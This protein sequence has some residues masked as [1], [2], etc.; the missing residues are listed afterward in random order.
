MPSVVPVPVPMAEQGDGS[1]AG[2]VQSGS[3]EGRRLG[4]KDFGGNWAAAATCGRAH[5]PINQRIWKGSGPPEH[6]GSEWR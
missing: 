2:Q 1:E 5:R 4:V 6:V 3:L